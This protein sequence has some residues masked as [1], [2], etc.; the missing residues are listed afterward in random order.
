[1]TDVLRI[2]RERMKRAK[3][4]AHG[5]TYKAAIPPGPGYDKRFVPGVGNVMSPIVFVGEAPG[6]DEAEEGVPF[7]GRSGAL[8]N[9]CFEHAGFIREDVYITNVV[10]FRP[11]NNRL[12][13]ATVLP[14]LPLMRMELR[15]IRPR[16]VVPLGAN[17]M[18]LWWPEPTV[19]LLA[20]QRFSQ[21]LQEGIHADRDLIVMPMYHPSWA[22]RQGQ[23]ARS[24]MAKHMRLIREALDGLL[25]VVK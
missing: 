8:L 9:E 17:A 23:D 22:L 12:D 16:L 14:A 1:M 25:K 20:G 13:D 4:Y 19:G 5:E 10:K 24:L 15:L 21:R 2:P 11:P 18:R 7:V 3:L 6:K